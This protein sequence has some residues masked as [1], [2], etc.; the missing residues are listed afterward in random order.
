MWERAWSTSA[1][2]KGKRDTGPSPSPPGQAAT[3]L[4]SPWKHHTKPQQST[5][6][7]EKTL[8]IGRM[9]HRWH[10]GI[11]LQGWPGQ[12]P[13]SPA[14]GL[15]LP[16]QTS[17][18]TGL[19]PRSPCTS[20][21]STRAWRS[22]KRSQVAFFYRNSQTTAP[23]IL[24]RPLKASIPSKPQGLGLAFNSFAQRRKKKINSLFR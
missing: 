13:P 24:H 23:N 4:P 7:M 18:T 16:A 2:I 6:D 19:M 8:P 17:H 10:P 1:V 20:E 12:S 15:S 22:S 21:C 5:P 11:Q 9:G 14:L 3:K